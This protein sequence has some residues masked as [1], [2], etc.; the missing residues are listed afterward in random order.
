MG[1]CAENEAPLRHCGM[2]WHHH[3]GNRN[4]GPDEEDEECRPHHLGAPQAF[5]PPSP[6]IPALSP[7]SSSMGDSDLGPGGGGGCPADFGGGANSDPPSTPPSDQDES[8]LAAFDRHHA[9]P[10]SRFGP[11]NPSPSSAAHHSPSSSSPMHHPRHHHVYHHGITAHQQQGGPFDHCPQADSA[12]LMPPASASLHSPDAIHGAKQHRQGGSPAN[13]HHHHHHHYRGASA[14]GGHQGG[15]PLPPAAQPL[16]RS[17]GA[18]GCSPTR[19]TPEGGSPGAKRE[20]WGKEEDAG[21]CAGCG[22]R[23]LDRYY[24]MAVE[25]RWHAACLQC[26]LCWRT[27][28]GDVTCYSKDGRIY[29]KRDYYM[30]FGVKRCARC[31][32]TITASELVMRARDLV[33]HLRCFTCFACGT[34][35]SKGDHFAMRHASVFCRLHLASA[36]AAGPH[37]AH[38]HLQRGRGPGGGGGGG[39]PEGHAADPQPPPPPPSSAPSVMPPGGSPTTGGGVAAAPAHH[40]HHMHHQHHHHPSPTP[41][42]AADFSAR[43][44]FR[45]STPPPPLIPIAMPSAP[46]GM[47]PHHPGEAGPPPPPPAEVP[48]FNGGAV[49][50]QK[51]RPR[52]RKPKTDLES[53]TAN[54]DLNTDPYLDVGYVGRGPEALSPGPVMGQHMG[55]PQQQRTKRMRTSFKHHQLRT[56]KSYF[57]INHNPDAKDL[58]Q[59][60]QK[61]GLPKRVLQVW[62]QNA[63]A[64]WR[65]MMLK[66]DSSSKC[67]G[68]GPHGD[69]P[70]DKGSSSGS[71]LMHGAPGPPSPPFAR[72]APSSPSA[73]LPT[74]PDMDQRPRGGFLAAAAAAASDCT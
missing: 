44:R 11:R 40:P 58:K 55:G 61:T 8:D 3:R 22:R 7:A 51:G 17:A 20:S 74:A 12:P 39:S 37:D 62:F 43:P 49:S 28:E 1:V 47:M 9:H 50:R 57:A 71:L 48:L 67:G 65:R 52:K 70:A 73:L 35:L 33:F 15:S 64:K 60:S 5:R 31:H 36:A 69:S 14:V 23:I 32:D 56:M 46:G 63:R 72:P 42:E 2:P 6:S 18:V 10:F 68:G 54:L 30:L 25:R 4:P 45:A 19:C 59:L 66:Q 29:C 16:A 24:L 21:A 27:L 34:A 26:S 13:H 53:M 38:P 41:P